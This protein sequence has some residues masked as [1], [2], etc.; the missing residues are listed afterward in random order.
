MGRTQGRRTL[1]W[2]F[3]IGLL[4]QNSSLGLVDDAWSKNVGE[5]PEN[6]F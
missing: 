6:K 1:G 3:K 2:T 5:K 4:A